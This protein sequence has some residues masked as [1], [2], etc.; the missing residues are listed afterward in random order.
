MRL[1]NRLVAAMAL[2]LCA[3]AV[4][5]NSGNV[6]AAQAGG[7]A[8]S[9]ALSKAIGSAARDHL[10]SLKGPLKDEL[11][12]DVSEYHCSLL[13]PG[14]ESCVLYSHTGRRMLKNFAIW[15]FGQRLT[16]EGAEQ[17]FVG[18]MNNIKASLPAGWRS[19]ET[20]VSRADPRELRTF[21][22]AGPP[23]SDALLQLKLVKRGELHAVSLQM[24][25]HHVD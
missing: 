4:Q 22:A 14:A 2:V 6:L 25:A 7:A 8:F 17:V 9:S 12:E 18:V 3:A 16:R 13:L 23:S 10:I 21:V 15:S 1:T 19:G 24:N 11:F 5:V 20:D